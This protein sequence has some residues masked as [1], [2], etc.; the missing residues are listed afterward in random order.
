MVGL[1]VDKCHPACGST[2]N[3]LCQMRA[4]AARNVCAYSKI[5]IAGKKE[6]DPDR[7]RHK[8]LVGKKHAHERE[9]SQR[10][11]QHVQPVTA[12]ASDIKMRGRRTDKGKYQHDPDDAK[13]FVHW[14]DPG[15]DIGL[16]GHRNSLLNRRNEPVATEMIENVKKSAERVFSQCQWSILSNHPIECGQRTYCVD[17]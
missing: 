16:E 1:K 9:Q 2:M 11:V 5:E 12:R 6:S 4:A 8:I 14:L 13:V 15:V 7:E 3:C 17:E 10:V